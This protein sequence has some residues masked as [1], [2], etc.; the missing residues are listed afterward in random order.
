MTV[1]RAEYQNKLEQYYGS[2]PGAVKTVMNFFN[3]YNLIIDLLHKVCGDPNKVAGKGEDYIRAGHEIE[4]VGQAIQQARGGITQWSGPGREAFDAKITDHVA[5]IEELGKA[6]AKTDEI[7]KAAAEACVQGANLI[8]DIVMM[9]IK[10]AIKSFLAALA[11][12]WCSFGATVA[13]WIGANVARGIQ[14]FQK[15]MSA[16]GKLGQ[17]LQKLAALLKKIAEILRKVKQ[18]L[19]LLQQVLQVT[20]QGDSKLGRLVDKGIGAIDRFTTYADKFDRATGGPGIEGSGSGAAGTS[21][22]GAG[23]GGT[24][25]AGQVPEGAVGGGIGGAIGGGSSGSLGSGSSGLVGT[26]IGA[27]TGQ[28]SG[29]GGSGAGSTGSGGSG[30][31][32]QTTTQIITEGV[33]AAA[34]DYKAG[35][36]AANRAQQIAAENRPPTF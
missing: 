13:A 7:L 4:A 25:G 14:A 18:I 6:V 3:A 26:V 10:W 27:V 15:I 36:A 21:G 34:E 32:S 33:K 5:K 9:V 30:A 16:L 31:G 35:R 12:S 20:G 11:T 24:V 2:A 29:S 17:F 1:A 23:G 28:G 19:Q 8:I 22:A